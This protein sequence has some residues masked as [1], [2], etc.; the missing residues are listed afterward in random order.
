MGKRNT[1][2]HAVRR[3]PASQSADD[4]PLIVIVVSRY[5]W[6]ITGKLL[7]GALKAF[8]EYLPESNPVIIEASGAFEIPQLCE[9]AACNKD[10]I[11]IVALGCIIKGE[12][13]HDRVLADAITPA[14]LDVAINNGVAVSLGVL[15]VDTPAQA[16]ARCGGENGTGP[17]NKGAEA[18]HALFQ[19]LFG[20]S[21]AVA[22]EAFSIESAAPD[23]ANPG[24]RKKRGGSGS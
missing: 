2:R 7:L 4:L 23:K 3:R 18:M 8:H 12:T 24:A 1:N 20:M 11:G 16:D 6:S 9:S 14:L 5:N 19:T 15:T 13:I 22:G 21:A 10:V 17:G